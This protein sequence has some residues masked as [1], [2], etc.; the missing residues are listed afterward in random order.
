[1]KRGNVSPNVYLQDEGISHLVFEGSVDP[2]FT[3][4]FSNTFSYKAFSLNIFVT[5]QAGNKI[6][7]YPAFKTAYSDFDALP[8][9]FTDRWEM[10][11]DETKTNVPSVLDAYQRYLVNN[12]GNFPYNNYNYSTERV[13][14]GSFVRLKTVSLT[15]NA[16][17]NILGKTPFKSLSLTAVS[18]NPWL[19]YSDPKLKGQDPE[20]FN[21]GGVAQ[22]IQK[23]FTLSLK[24][25]L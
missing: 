19:I 23:Q 16:T 7:L 17:Q 22:P 10:P 6:R 1:M 14:D 25:G 21:T 4:G 11:G 9:E 5:Y 2:E 24:A 13:A 8:K 20:F 18:S 12:T 3:G 15:Y